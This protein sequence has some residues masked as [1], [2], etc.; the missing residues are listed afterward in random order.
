MMR[1]YYEYQKKEEPS[2]LIWAAYG[3]KALMH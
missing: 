1:S 3:A 2:F